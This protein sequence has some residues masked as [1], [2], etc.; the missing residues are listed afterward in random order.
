M[1]ARGWLIDLYVREDI[2]VL[3]FRLQSGTLLCLTDSFP[4]RFYA[5][6]RPRDLLALEKTLSYLIRRTNWTKRREF[7]TGKLIPVLELEAVSFKKLFEIQKVLSR[8]LEAISFYNIDLA[9]P[10]YYAYLKGLFPLCYCQLKWEEKRLL[11]FELLDS[12]WNPDAL[13]PPF[14]TIELGLTQDPQIPLDRGNSLELIDEGR[15]FELGG[16]RPAE[17]LEKLNTYLVDLNPDLIISRKGDDRILPILW[18]WAQKEKIPLALDRDPHPPLRRSI[19]QW[20]SYFSYG[21]IIYQGSI[22]PLYGRFHID[23]SNSFFFG[24]GECGLKG[25]FFLSRLTKIPVQTMARSTPGTAITSMQLNRAVRKGI[26]IPW[27]KGRPEDF[28]TAWDLLVADKGGLVFQP[29]IG[30]RE[31]VAEIDFA[32]MYPNIMLQHNISPETMLCSC[33]PGPVVPEIGYNI[34]QKREG[35]IPETLRPILDLRAEL[36]AR[37]KANHPLKDSYQSLSKGP[38]MGSGYLLRVHRV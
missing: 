30:L 2:I 1:T 7:W 36:K 35:L 4:Y 12:P 34:C 5:Q 10:Q 16:S 38:Q 37:I 24:H 9:V 23:Q 25:V 31:N 19:G 26:L 32:S 11:G 3:W 22:F 18:N 28:K 29:P 14:K 15:S 20:R 13:L 8:F 21:Q 17:L 27:K 33:C 6:G